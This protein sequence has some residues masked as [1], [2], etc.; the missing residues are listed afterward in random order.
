MMTAYEV[1]PLKP[2]MDLD[3]VDPFSDDSDDDM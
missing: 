1:E 3:E 2:D